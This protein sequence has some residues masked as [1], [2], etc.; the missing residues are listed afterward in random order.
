MRRFLF[1]AA[2]SL[3]CSLGTTAQDFKLNEADYFENQGAGIMVFDDVYPEGH[4]GGITIATHG[5]RRA[6][7]GDV[8]FEI[9]Q[10]QWQGLPKM[11]SRVVDK[12]ANE[13]RVTL[14][15][16]DSKAKAT[17]SWSPSTWTVPSPNASQANWASTSNSCPPPSWDSP[18]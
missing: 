18:G 9:S 6:A 12:D 5:N 13:I 17:T 15:Y 14:S 4:Q 11:R 16:P 2:A 3:L 10:G 7:V 8:R 1:C